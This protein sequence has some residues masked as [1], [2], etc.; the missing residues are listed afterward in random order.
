MKNNVK[1]MKNKKA[2]IFDMGGVLVDLDMDGCRDAFKTL[3]G[4]HK[5]DEL[6]DPCHQKGIIGDLEEGMLTAD[7]FRKTVLSES[8]PGALPEN[9]DKAFWQIL[10]SISSYKGDLLRRMT[11]SYDLYMLSNNNPITMVRAYQLFQEVGAPIDEVFKK[12][13][14]SYQMK[15]LKPS[16][17][18]Y[19][20]VVQQIGIPS[21]Q[22][23]FIDDSKAN[24]EGAIAAG[25]PSVHYVPGTDLS[26]LLAE[27]LED[28]SL[29]MEVAADA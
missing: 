26:A 14:L 2:I 3:L 1:K 21:E 13:F 25:L 9:V 8:E 10:G 12:C 29:K 28:S 4:Y 22:L 6:L 5:I 27:V 20:A 16:E 23:L 15:A 18:F 17:T 7:E 19:K 24:V 11:E